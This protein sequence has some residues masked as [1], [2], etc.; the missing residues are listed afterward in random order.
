MTLETARAG[1][2]AVTGSQNAAM[3]GGLQVSDSAT[4]IEKQV[5]S[6]ELRKHSR[7]IEAGN[8]IDRLWM[9]DER[10]DEIVSLC[11]IAASHLRLSTVFLLVFA[12]L[13]L[14]FAGPRLGLRSDADGIDP[15][16]EVPPAVDPEP[17]FAR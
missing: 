4:Q 16:V 8:C 12:V 5:S 11:D 14:I 15:T 7:A 6:P 9:E 1:P 17:A 2:R 3:L 10:F 13:I